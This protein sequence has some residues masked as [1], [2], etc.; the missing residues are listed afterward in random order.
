MVVNQVLVTSDTVDFSVII[1]LEF[2]PRERQNSRTNQ[3]PGFAI[4]NVSPLSFDSN[5]SIFLLQTGEEV[6]RWTKCDCLSAA[7]A[8]VEGRKLRGKC[9]QRGKTPRLE[10]SFERWTVDESYNRIAAAVS[11]GLNYLLSFRSVIRNDKNRA[12]WSSFSARAAII[13]H[14]FES[15]THSRFPRFGS[16]SFFDGTFHGSMSETLSDFAPKRETRGIVKTF[17]ATVIFRSLIIRYRGIMLTVYYVFIIFF[18][19]F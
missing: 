11:P 3:S 7:V 2:N 1:L 18:Y 6:A 17:L 9:P 16:R 15:G 4:A 14:A 8:K 13:Q 5:T 19:D 12:R 10:R